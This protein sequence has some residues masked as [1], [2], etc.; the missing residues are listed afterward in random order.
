MSDRHAPSD[1]T[2]AALGL[3]GAHLTPLKSGLIN[4]SWLVALQS[5]EQ[6]VLQLL[7]P[8]FP[9]WINRDIDAI[10]KHLAAKG[11]RTPRLIALPDGALWLEADEAVW[12]MLSY[13][14]GTTFDRLRDA[15]QAREA[16]ALLA[17]FHGALVDCEH[18]FAAARLGVHDLALHVAALEEAV[19]QQRGHRNYAIVAPLADAILALA[20][21]LGELPHTPDRN[22]HGDPKISNIVFDPDDGR[23]LCMIDL[24]T[25]ARMPLALELGDAIRSW[26]NPAGEDSPDAALSLPYFRSA[27]Q[28]YAG[29]ARGFVVEDEWRSFPAAGLRIAVELATRFCTDALE[30]RY[31]GWDA[32][33]FGSASEHNIVRARAQLAL[34]ESIAAGLT[35]LEDE[36]QRAF[37]G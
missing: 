26:C 24:D 25:L 20:A 22:V 27:M 31:F 1:R 6:R 14:P 18:S 16:G 19:Q 13:V 28:G 34:A 11:F 32:T 21:A 12:R 8:I 15:D 7:N 23:A 33:R 35:E 36:T 17:R 4:T 37:A 2:L 5:G 30:E 9:P 10:T 29:F 3:T